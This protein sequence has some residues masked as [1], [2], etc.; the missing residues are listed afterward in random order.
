ME[1]LDDGVERCHSVAGEDAVPVADGVAWWIGG[2]VVHVDDLQGRG[3]EQL[4]TGEFGP[5]LV[6]MIDIGQQAG[7]RMS[8]FDHGEDRLAQAVQVLGKAPY[9]QFRHHPHLI[10]QL[11]QDTVAPGHLHQVE[12]RA[13]SR[14][15]RG[16]CE[17][18]AAQLGHEVHVSLGLLESLGPLGWIIDDP[19]GK[20]NGALN[21]QSCVP[22]P[23]CQ[24]PE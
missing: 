1:I 11:E 18:L 4:E 8:A 23:L 6:N 21:G 2:I 9:L 12:Q 3:T 16:C 14:P 24:I 10:P 20:S 19:L 5:A 22:D 17:A 13:T 7:T 15:S